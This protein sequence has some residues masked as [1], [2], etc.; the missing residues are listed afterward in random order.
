MLLTS[1]GTGACRHFLG[2]KNTDLTIK[3]NINVHQQWMHSS[4]LVQLYVGDVYVCAYTLA[5]PQSWLIPCK[6]WNL[7]D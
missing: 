6:Y 2:E 5:A 7:D 1:T 3:Y 4:L